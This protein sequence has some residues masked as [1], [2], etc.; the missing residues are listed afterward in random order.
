MLKED[1][2][3]VENWRDR[4]RGKHKENKTSFSI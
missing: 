4:E 2:E 1:E 3:K